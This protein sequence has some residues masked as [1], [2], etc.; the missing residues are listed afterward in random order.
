MNLHRTGKKPD[1]EKVPPAERS[2]YQRI[3]A[4]TGGLLTPPNVITAIGLVIVLY[5]LY[6]LLTEFYW[7]GLICLAI[8]RLL[9]IVDGWVAEA[10]GTKSPFGELLDATVDKI[11][12]LLTIIVFFAAGIA[13]WWLVSLLLLPQVVIPLVTL[14]KRAIK[15]PIHPTRIGKLSMAATW[16]S[17]LGLILLQAIALPWP[18]AVAAIVYLL[19]GLSVSLGLTALW[20]YATDRG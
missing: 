1:W 8:G 6:A 18:S 10:T 11:G 17:L 16:V 7:T 20:Q 15:A 19:I 2:T 3:A 4:Q 5:G 13:D 14:Y 9:D 12:T